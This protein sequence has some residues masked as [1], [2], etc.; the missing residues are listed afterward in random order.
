MRRINQN[1]SGCPICRGAGVSIVTTNQV[2]SR[3]PYAEVKV[4]LGEER[5]LGPDRCPRKIT[6]RMG[7]R[8]SPEEIEV[9]ISRGELWKLRSEGGV[10]LFCIPSHFPVLEMVDT[11]PKL[12]RDL[13]GLPKPK[14]GSIRPP[15]LPDWVW[16]MVP[17]AGVL[18]FSTGDI[19][20]A[21]M[22]CINT[23]GLYSGI[24]VYS[25]DMVCPDGYGTPRV[26]VFI[27]DDGTISI[28]RN[29]KVGDRLY[30]CGAKLQ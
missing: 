1:A 9:P 14:A 12:F 24:R 15:G 7:R 6:E 5:V 8:P 22:V 19:K 11:Y 23:V 28:P 27:A 4:F 20:L 26:S 17:S 18:P 10:K 21:E 29:F 16:F 3:I 25:G 2:V 30:A 13:S